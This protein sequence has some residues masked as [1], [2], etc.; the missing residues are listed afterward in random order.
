MK[1]EKAELGVEARLILEPG[2]AV[3]KDNYFD[4]AQLLTQT[5]LA[6]E[7]FDAMVHGAPPRWCV[8]GG[9]MDRDI[10]KSYAEMM[11]QA[12]LNILWGIKSEFYSKLAEALFD[13]KDAFQSTGTVEVSG[14][15]IIR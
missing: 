9:T 14:E 7:V 5:K 13:L 4:N 8:K 6:M 1:E 11:R 3:G 10:F 15:L 12:S 2:G